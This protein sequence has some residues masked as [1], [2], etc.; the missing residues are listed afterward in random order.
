MAFADAHCHLGSR[1]YDKDRDE[2]IGRMLASGVSKAIIICCS[3][4][5]LLEGV[6]LREE[7]PGFKLAVSIHPQD[8]EDDHSE[9]RLTELRRVIEEF[10]PDMIGETGLDYYSHPHTKLQ[11]KH[12][13]ISQLEMAGHYGLPVNVHSRK[14]SADTLEILKSHK[15]PGIIHSYSGSIEMARLFIREGYY[16]SFGASVLFEGAR[17]P[18]E[19]ISQIPLERLLIETDSPY[20]SP[21]RDHRHEPED[22][23]R[24]YQAISNIRGMSVL[25]LENAV[26][27]N[28]DRLF[29]IK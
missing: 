24:I 28:F 8:L 27:E 13:F 5:D 21:I 15:V 23:I 18:A 26:E 22:I 3:R 17:K 25:Q 1:Q 14:A 12:F 29:Q 20:Q 7:N 9:E 16:I 10:H 19:V 11:Q 6:R 4:H 2:M